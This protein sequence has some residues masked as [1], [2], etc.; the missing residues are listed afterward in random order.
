[1][2]IKVFNKLYRRM[3]GLVT[4]VF[5][6]LSLM[7]LFLLFLIFRTSIFNI[8]ISEHT[9][10][11]VICIGISLLLVSQGMA[12]FWSRRITKPIAEISEAVD[13]IAQGNFDVNIK[14]DGFKYEIKGLAENINKMTEELKSIEVMRSDFVSNVSHEFKA[15]LATIQ[16]YVTLLS[17]KNL[18]EKKRDEYFRLLTESTSQISGLV[19]SVLR[20]SRLETQNILARPEEFSLDEQLRLVVLMFETQWSAK[21]LYLELDLPECKCVAQK[22]LLYQMWINLIGNA[23]KFT[24]NGGKIGVKIIDED[25]DFIKVIIYDN[26]VGMSEDVKNHIFEKFYQGDESRKSQGNG[27]GLALVH[28]ITELTDCKISVESAENKG[29]AFTVIVPKN[30]NKI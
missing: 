21:D 7:L 20:L 10:L 8:N 17:D 6:L 9:Y 29:T 5:V 11:I 4:L 14:D 1:M 25:T 19:D 15:P 27:L 23:V 28:K 3:I 26:G 12:F 24:D 30:Q 18:D 22:D 16:G 13:K 2:K